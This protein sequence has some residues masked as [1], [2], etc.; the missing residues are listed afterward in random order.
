MMPTKSSASSIS[1][2]RFHE[3]TVF[4]SNSLSSLWVSILIDFACVLTSTAPGREIFGDEETPPGTNRCY[5]Q[6]LCQVPVRPH[7]SGD[8]QAAFVY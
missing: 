8:F 3:L 1:R 7:S 5:G 2:K 4:L 6:G